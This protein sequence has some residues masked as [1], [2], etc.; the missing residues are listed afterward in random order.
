MFETELGF[1]NIENVELQILKLL[2]KELQSHENT[3]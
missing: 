3:R 1:I 2:N